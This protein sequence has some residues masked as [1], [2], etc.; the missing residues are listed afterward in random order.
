MLVLLCDSVIF[1]SVSEDLRS[2]SAK[3]TV[4][5]VFVFDFT[6]AFSY[7]L[8]LPVCKIVECSTM[9]CF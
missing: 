7:D 3:V 4:V 8:L 6:L 5:L 9:S 1:A 2:E